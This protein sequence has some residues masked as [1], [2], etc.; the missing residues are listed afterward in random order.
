MRIFQILV[1]FTNCFCFVDIRAQY[2]SRN[3]DYPRSSYTP[4]DNRYAEYPRSSY[5]PSDNRFDYNGYK[6]R[7][8]STESIRSD[9]TS[10]L[11]KQKL[12]ASRS[13]LEEVVKEIS[14]LERQLDSMNQFQ[15]NRIDNNSD[16]KDF[17]F[18][19]EGVTIDESKPLWVAGGYSLFGFNI[20]SDESY[21][22]KRNSLSLSHSSSLHK[23][24]DL[25]YNF[26]FGKSSWVNEYYYLS[27]PNETF[28]EDKSATEFDFSLGIRYHLPFKL[29][30][31]IIR[32]VSPFVSAELG[33][34]LYRGDQMVDIPG[35]S[36]SYTPAGDIWQWQIKFGTELFLLDKFSLIP[37]F[38]YISK[39]NSEIDPYTM[40]GVDLVYYLNR[41]FGLRA[42]YM[43]GSDKTNL[44]LSVVVSW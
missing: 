1:L 5:T 41:R 8:R 39:L 22:Y 34:E 26:S 4:S 15:D 42:G 9:K 37:H 7:P 25:F 27:N 14:Y 43:L 40:Y 36:F 38:N 29:R 28:S 12:S 31:S 30:N 2:D 19:S 23:N 17:G 33:Y 16:E 32:I 24:F 6:E 18:A 35:T 3:V 20:R 11:I 13:K 10:T 44:D 21:D